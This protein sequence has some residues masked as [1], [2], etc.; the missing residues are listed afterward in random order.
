VA[1]EERAGGGAGDEQVAAAVAAGQ[2]IAAVADQGVV[3]AR[4]AAAA[5]GD[6]LG[7]GD[8][9][10][11]AGGG[12]GVGVDDYAAGMGGIVQGGGA[13]AAVDT[14]IDG[15]AVGEDEGIVRI[16]AIKVR[17]PSERDGADKQRA[18]QGAG[19]VGGD[20]PGVDRVGGEQGNAAA[21]T[22]DEV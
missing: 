8:T 7:V 16:A 5:A 10:P 15:G 14:A 11:H 18:A 3:N 21:G 4:A 12:T 2:D 22:A 6:V 1:A 17:C 13:A 20:G 9:G 19:V